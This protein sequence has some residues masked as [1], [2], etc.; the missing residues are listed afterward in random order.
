[1][2]WTYRSS[3]RR[4]RRP[5]RSARPTRPGWRS[6]CG[7]TWRRCGP[8][9]TPTPAGARRCRPTSATARTGNGPRRWSA[10]STGPTDGPDAATG[11]VTKGH[12]ARLPGRRQS[13]RRG[14]GCFADG[15]REVLVRAAALDRELELVA[16]LAGLHHVQQVITVVDVLVAGL[17]DDVALLE[18]A[19]VRRR[20]ADH[21]GDAPAAVVV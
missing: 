16:D 11:G 12:A 20:P 6:A 2:S 8:T 4:S 13:F 21:A 1:M 18:A 3:V 5:R 7:R 19:L 15:H 17:D 14:S 10:P 9:G